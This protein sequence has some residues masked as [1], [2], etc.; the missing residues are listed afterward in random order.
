MQ[1]YGGT[2]K[3][4]L[5]SCIAMEDQNAR[6]ERTWAL[7]EQRHDNKHIYMRQLTGRLITGPPVSLQDPKGMTRLVDDLLICTDCL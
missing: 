5:R 1:A 6:Y 2:M 7:L 4:N 3:E